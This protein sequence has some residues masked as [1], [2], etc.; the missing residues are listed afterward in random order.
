KDTAIKLTAENSEVAEKA[1]IIF[2]GVK[3]PLVL[4]VLDGL[5][6]NLDNK[7]VI[8]LAGG[9]RI[10][11]MEKTSNARIMRALTNT[12]SAICRAAT[13]ITRGSR[14]TNEDVDLAKKILGAIGV[15]VEVDE[16]KIDI[17]TAL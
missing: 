5:K 8:S 15:V 9:V 14:S 17:V 13:G 10:A 11:S 6:D 7:L 3:P 1:E 2:I 16:D 4:P 12:S